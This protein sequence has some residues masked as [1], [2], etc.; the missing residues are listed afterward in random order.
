MNAEAGQ[1]G[2]DALVF[3]EARWRGVALFVAVASVFWIVSL[4][5]FFTGPKPE[6]LAGLVLVDLV[7]GAAV[8][9]KMLTV[10]RPNPW[11]VV[12]DGGAIYLRMHSS[13]CREDQSASALLRL[14]LDEVRSVG[15]HSKFYQM[16][17]GK[18]F[19]GFNHWRDSIDLALRPGDWSELAEILRQKRRRYPHL[20]EGDGWTV[21]KK[22]SLC[23]LS[24]PTPH[25]IRICWR[26]S[27]EGICLSPGVSHAAD[28]FGGVIEIRDVDR[29]ETVDC[30]DLDPQNAL[31]VIIELCDIGLEKE[32]EAVVQN[33][34]D[35]SSFD[36][37]E[38]LEAILAR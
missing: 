18:G 23:R 36:C 28:R 4:I 12:V 1:F 2:S 25:V 31:P 34:L 6:N 14:S 32:A 27:G 21:W 19:E 29:R 9:W 20:K 38:K 15:G 5:A 24:M 16:R 30:S 3:R 11:W 13:E 22:N 26:D 33:C 35:A 37:R 7:V 10:F 8:I 17:D